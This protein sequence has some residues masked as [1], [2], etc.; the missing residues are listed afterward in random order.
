MSSVTKFNFLKEGMGS[1]WWNAWAL[2]ELAGYPNSI[3]PWRIFTIVHDTGSVPSQGKEN[4][5]PA[6]QINYWP[7]LSHYK[8]TLWKDGAALCQRWLKLEAQWPHV[9]LTSPMHQQHS[10]FLFNYPLWYQAITTQRARTMDFYFITL[11]NSRI[12]ISSRGINKLIYHQDRGPSFFQ[13]AHPE[14]LGVVG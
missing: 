4:T 13:R 6:F 14:K 7:F 2:F 3:P 11:T 8:Q 10:A 5:P 9:A 12:E 1:H